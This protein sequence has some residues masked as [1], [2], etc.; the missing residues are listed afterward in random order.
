M[1][2]IKKNIAPKYE[3]KPTKTI[4][5]PTIGVHNDRIFNER[6]LKIDEE[7]KRACNMTINT[8]E[9]YTERNSIHDRSTIERNNERNEIK[10]KFK[11]QYYQEKFIM[12]T[13]PSVDKDFM[14][15]EELDIKPIEKK[16]LIYEKKLS[17]KKLSMPSQPAQIS[18]NLS[19]TILTQPATLMTQQR[20]TKKTDKKTLEKE[21]K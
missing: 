18:Q 4:F 14:C 7:K 10:E 21:L 15:E 5:K 17:E 9:R 1:I 2:E 19:S 11:K 3:V 16:P 8:T 6:T 12:N 13:S 20:L